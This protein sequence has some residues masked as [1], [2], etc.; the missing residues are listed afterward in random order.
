MA[1]WRA[2]T[3][4][5]AVAACAL[6]GV[7]AGTGG[8]VDTA[9][10]PA[11]TLVGRALLAATAYQAGPASGAKVSAANGVTP[12]F[13][14]QPIPGFSAVLAAGDG[15][16]WAMPDNGFG[17]KANSADFLLRL[18]RVRPDLRTPGGGGG[19]IA[20]TEFLS[21]RD[22]DR[23]IGFELT[24]ANRLLTGADFDLESVRRA[25]DGTFWFGEEFGPFLL[26]T[27]ATGKVLEAPF[28]LPGVHSP[29]YPG[30][31]PLTANLPASKGFEGMAID[32][33]GLFLYPMLEGA[34]A[35]DADPR[36]RVLFQF[37]L[38]KRRYTG[39]TWAYRVDEATPGGLIGDLTA[40]DAHRFLLIERD[41][42]Q[43]ADA[44]QKKIYLI[45]LRR[46]DPDGYLTK[47]LVLDL[48]H[49]ADPHGI[50]SPA[51]PGEFGVGPRFSFPLQ[52]VESLL[53]LDD[54]RLLIANDNNFPS[55]NG[56]W[57]ARDR[58]DDVEVVVV[59]LDRPLG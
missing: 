55:S 52:S 44:R 3:S 23:R 25:P 56:R 35:T 2:R 42:G 13:G 32:P 27:D 50:S 36:R 53:I 1:N 43:G 11:A 19:T 10:P 58:P 15:E 28:R 26:H 39:K 48:L 47:T 17:S 31:N 7:A 8:A 57:T 21:L 49:I 14:G 45:D 22:P 5:L 20:V 54:R 29:Q 24:R 16:Y 33:A 6:T 46:V 38:T 41:D 4:G 59:E 37:D 40:L 34:L 9:A 12:P 18:Y 51:R 30:R